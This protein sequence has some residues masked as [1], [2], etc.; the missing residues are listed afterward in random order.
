M[1]W[2]KTARSF[3]IPTT[4][5]G[6]LRS[7]TSTSSSSSWERAERRR[8]HELERRRK[9]TEKMQELERARFEVEVYENYISVIRSIH[10]ECKRTW[11][12]PRVKDTPAPEAPQLQHTSESEA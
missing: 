11:D 2:K 12:W 6:V 10:K 1:G 9:E 3:G 8:Q 5:R 4:A 7:M